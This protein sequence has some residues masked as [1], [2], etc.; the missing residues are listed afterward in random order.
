MKC[1]NTLFSPY[2]FEHKQLFIAWEI[3]VE[4]HDLESE[5][6]ICILHVSI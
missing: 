6:R 3:A 2:G 5:A 4:R 1:E